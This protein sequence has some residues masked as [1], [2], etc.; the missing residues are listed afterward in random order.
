MMSHLQLPDLWSPTPALLVPRE[1]EVVA[2]GAVPVARLRH[3]AE[4]APAAAPAAA[5][6]AAG[7]RRGWPGVGSA[8]LSALRVPVGRVMYVQVHVHERIIII[9]IDIDTLV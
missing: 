5:A 2:A 9:I 3:L 1:L 8:A 7:D 6:V 4:A